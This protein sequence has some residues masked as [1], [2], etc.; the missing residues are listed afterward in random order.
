MILMS[1][2][3]SIYASPP[4]DLYHPASRE[5]GTSGRSW[6]RRSWFL[7]SFLDPHTIPSNCD[8]NDN[9]YDYDYNHDFDYYDDN[10]EEDDDIW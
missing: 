4:Q 6:L 10:D 9:D 5:P 2:T 1:R 8:D 7:Y 3:P